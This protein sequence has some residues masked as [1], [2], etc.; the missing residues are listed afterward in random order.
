MQVNV[1]SHQWLFNCQVA[2][3]SPPGVCLRHDVDGVLW[4]PLQDVADNQ[5][6]WQHIATFH[7][8]GYVQVPSN[9]YVISICRPIPMQ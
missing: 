4:V 2:A 5:S 7:A 3:D 9:I 8:L 1:G 6:P